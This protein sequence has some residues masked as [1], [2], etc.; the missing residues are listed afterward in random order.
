MDLGNFSISL[1]VKD[2]A[3]ARAFYEAFGFE[4]IFGEPEQ[5]WI[6]VGN[7]EAKIGLFQ[8]MFEENIITFNPK[9]ARAIQKTVV[10]A[11]YTVEKRAEDGEG[12]CHFTIKDPDGNAVLVDQHE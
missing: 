2:L 4:Q 7:G 5:G 12:P 11:G 3:K 8:G 10:D 9:D 1:A 6:I